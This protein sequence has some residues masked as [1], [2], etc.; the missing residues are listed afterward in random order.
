MWNVTTGGLV[1]S[2]LIKIKGIRNIPGDRFVPLLVPLSNVTNT[3]F[4][5]R[6]TKTKYIQKQLVYYS[7]LSQD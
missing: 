5:D 1:Y 4:K 3:K 7:K 6:L 2:N